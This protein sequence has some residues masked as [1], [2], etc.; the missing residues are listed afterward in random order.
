MTQ[1]ACVP[2]S[3]RS[4][5][6]ARSRHR[7]V[8][9]RSTSGG[10]RVACLQ[11]DGDDGRFPAS[12]S[13]VRTIV[14]RCGARGV[15]ALAVA[16]MFPSVANLRAQD[17]FSAVRAHAAQ[18][19]ADGTIAGLAV[20][21]ARNGAI[22]W[23]E[24]FGWADKERGEP[25]TQHTAMLLASV[26]KPITTTGLMVLARR[27][28]I[29]LD[30][31][32]NEYLGAAKLV[33]KVGDVREATVRRVANHTAGLSRYGRGYAADSAYLAQTMD[34][35]IARY[36]LIVFPPGER[37]EYSNLGYGLLSDLIARVSGTPFPAFMR[38]EVFEP[39]GLTSTFVY[40]DTRGRRDGDGVRCARESPPA[41]CL[42]PC[43]GLVRVRDG[44]RPRATR[45][46]SPQ[47]SPPR[48]APAPLGQ[49]YRRDA[50]ANHW[51]CGRSV[52]NGVESIRLG[53]D[54][55][56]AAWSPRGWAHRRRWWCV[57]AARIA[58]GSGSG[59]GGDRQSGRGRSTE[60][61]ARD[62][63]GAGSGRAISEW[64]RDE[65]VLCVAAGESGRV[66]FDR[67]GS[68]AKCRS[69]LRA[70]SQSPIHAF[71]T[72]CAS[73]CASSTGVCAVLCRPG[74]AG[75]GRLTPPS[76]FGSSCVRARPP[77]TS[78]R[79]PLRRGRFGTGPVHR[80]FA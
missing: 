15:V 78:R 10:A 14:P 44:R 79:E 43:R 61:C 66:G 3:S 62:P 8:R 23:E 58:P 2:S 72:H 52:Q 26:S 57:G 50:S 25:L 13:Y 42:R 41:I 39:L 47:G 20:A 65:H 35:I 46:V 59:G 68:G 34:E 53:M 36:G 37:F 33:A 18:L 4:H 5:G 70:G 55:L 54:H 21:V 1:P 29:D 76:H 64:G 7:D 32:I 19:V 51:R 22:I 75:L 71:R 77:G 27:G 48:S 17:Q 30:T 40:P 12:T 38:A 45:D 74:P 49:C 24:A 60:H 11:A 67:C 16:I 6:T 73:T 9:G 28:S 69:S 80:R 63:G 31:P 56:V